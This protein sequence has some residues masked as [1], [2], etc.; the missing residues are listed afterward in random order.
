GAVV[1]KSVLNEYIDVVAS[2]NDSI[3]SVVD[4][5]VIDVDNS[6]AENIDIAL[7]AATNVED[8]DVNDVGLESETGVSTYSYVDADEELE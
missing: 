7:K 5:F 3:D 8:M 6:E 4:N 1:E 2:K